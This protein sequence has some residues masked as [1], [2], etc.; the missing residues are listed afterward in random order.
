MGWLA[1]KSVEH[2][3]RNTTYGVRKLVAAADVLTAAWNAG[4]QPTQ[5]A[6]SE[7]QRRKD[8]LVTDMLGT[9]GIAQ[10]RRTVIEPEL[11][12]LRAH[13][14]ARSAVISVCDWIA[15][16]TASDGLAE[17]YSDDEIIALASQ[18]RRGAIARLLGVA[19]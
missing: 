2:Q 14:D 10:L 9:V 17:T 12:S 16:Q 7:F 3:L 13:A 1:R 15:K 6:L 18:S 4:G 5:E 11:E 19:D 8:K